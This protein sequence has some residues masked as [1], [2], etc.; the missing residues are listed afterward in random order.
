MA[1]LVK[2]LLIECGVAQTRAALLR[3]GQI[4]KFWF[5]PARGDEMSDRFQGAGRRFAGRIKKT[6]KSLAAA[7]VDLGDGRD[8]FLPIKKSNESF[9]IDGALIEVEI[10]TPPRQA[11]GAAL[12]FVG[13]LAEGTP[14]RMPPFTDPALEAVQ[15]IG[16]HADEILVDDGRALRLLH[17]AGFEKASHESHPVSLFEKD[18]VDQEFDAAFDRVVPLAGGGCLFIDEAQAL[19]AIDVDSGGLAASSP[20]RLREKIAFAAAEEAMRQISLRNIGGHIVIDFPDIPGEAG[21]KRFQAHL[22]K[23]MARLDGASASSFSRSGLYSFTAPHHALSM[24]DR[25]TEEDA[26]APIPGRR[27]TIG[28]ASTMALAVLERRLRSAPTARLR[29]CV[30]AAIAGYLDDHEIW[31]ERLTQCY[32]PRFDIGTDDTCG[33]RNFDLAEQ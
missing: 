33:D 20:A 7:F 9:C 25:F 11:K 5:G 19:T 27:F 13:P 23:M 30:G 21:R 3:N 24:L 10:K 28:A 17:E 6:D 32:G 26:A 2:R 15:E 18:G 31:R 4:W 8:A 12:R 14:G 22:R 16:D 1:Q 29:L